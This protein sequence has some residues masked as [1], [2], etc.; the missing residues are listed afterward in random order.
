MLYCSFSSEQHLKNNH[1]TTD[2]ININATRPTQRAVTIT[3]SVLQAGVDCKDHSNDVRTQNHYRHQWLFVDDDC[4]D[5]D[6]SAI[7]PFDLVQQSEDIHRRKDHQ[8]IMGQM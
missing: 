3:Y 1:S 4:Q 8:E 7:R 5:K 2:F 6:L